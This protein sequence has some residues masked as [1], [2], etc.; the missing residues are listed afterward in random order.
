MRRQEDESSASGPW[1]LGD[2]VQITGSVDVS[3]DNDDAKETVFWEYSLKAIAVFAEYKNAFPL[4]F[5]KLATCKFEG[6]YSAQKL[7]GTD[8]SKVVTRVCVT[9]K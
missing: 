8:G 5:E 2:S 9:Y 4:L 7:F 3:G 6:R 1:K